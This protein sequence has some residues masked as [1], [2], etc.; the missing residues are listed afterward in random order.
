MYIDAVSCWRGV[1]SGLLH[2]Q[3]CGVGELVGGVGRV[4]LEVGAQPL[5]TIS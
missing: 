1:V 4:S 5:G 3:E 2:Y